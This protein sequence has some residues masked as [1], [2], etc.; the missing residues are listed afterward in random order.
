MPKECLS[1]LQRKRKRSLQGL[2][3]F[4]PVFSADTK[5]I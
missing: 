5:P 3:P 4:K 1:H 2:S